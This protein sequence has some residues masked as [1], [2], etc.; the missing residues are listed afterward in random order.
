LTK[1]TFLQELQLKNLNT[2][3]AILLICSATITGCTSLGNTG[4]AKETGE[5]IE[6]KITEGITTKQ[7]VVDWLGVPTETTFTDSGQEVIKY[8]YQHIRPRAQNYI[9]YNFIS[10]VSDTKNKE[11]VILLNNSN[12]VQ[13]VVMN[14]SKEQIRWG[15]IE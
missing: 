6:Q 1:S 7:T 2:A 8:A 14:E 11:L 5:S 10:Q 3:T 9:P 4:L 15:M 13:K 12:V